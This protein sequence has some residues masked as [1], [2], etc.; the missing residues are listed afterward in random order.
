MVPTKKFPKIKTLENWLHIDYNPLTGKTSTFGY[1]PSPLFKTLTP[2]NPLKWQDAYYQGIIALADC[3]EEVGGFHCVP[4]FHNFC[5]EWTKLNLEHCED[6]HY[7][8]DPTTVQI[9]TDDELRKYLQKIP[10]RKGCLLI[11]D[12]RLAHANFPNQS[13][14]PRLVQYVKWNAVDKG[15]NSAV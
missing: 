11:W 1:E 14:D 4:G 9:P 8:N 5:E 15:I 6:S 7:S 13:E 12:G 3:P 10:I 2:Q